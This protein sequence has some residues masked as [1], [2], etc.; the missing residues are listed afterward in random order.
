MNQSKWPKTIHQWQTAAR[1][2]NKRYT[3][4]KN[5]G[6]ARSPR[7]GKERKQQWKA[8]IDLTNEDSSS[9]DKEL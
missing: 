6:L 4:K 2:E 7:D 1:E 9:N 3:I 5:L 8:V